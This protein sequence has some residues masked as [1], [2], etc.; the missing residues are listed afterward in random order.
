MT[1]A[2]G[3]SAAAEIRNP[4]SAFL[5]NLKP[6]PVEPASIRARP[7]VKQAPAAPVYATRPS[8]ATITASFANQAAPP[9]TRA[10]PATAVQTDVHLGDDIK[11]PPLYRCLHLEPIAFFGRAHPPA[12]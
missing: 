2:T 1:N 6:T 4:V 5:A 10:T 12:T 3:E 11:A 8:V 7:R 9:R